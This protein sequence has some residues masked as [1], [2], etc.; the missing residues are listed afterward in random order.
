MLF[1]DSSTIKDVILFPHE[2]SGAKDAQEAGEQNNLNPQM[3]D[4]GARRC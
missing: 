3:R 1:T 2:A 4:L